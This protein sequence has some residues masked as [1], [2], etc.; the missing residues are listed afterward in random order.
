MIKLIK[1][2]ICKQKGHKWIYAVHSWGIHEDIIEKDVYC[3]RCKLKK[4]ILKY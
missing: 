1:N 2:F 4:D 3:K